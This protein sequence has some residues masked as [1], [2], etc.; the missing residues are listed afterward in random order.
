MDYLK[1]LEHSYATV[2]AV[3]SCPPESRLEYLSDA[4]FEFTTDESG[5]SEL[6]AS[7]AIDVCEAINDR[8][9]FEYIKDRDNRMWF[10]LMCNMPFFSVRIECGTSVRGSW[11]LPCDLEVFGLYIGDEQLLKL[12]FPIGGWNEFVTALVSFARAGDKPSEGG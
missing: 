11:W 5:M 6:F 1:L 2:C 10:L 8:K 12:D 3:Y 9:T 7:K 4:I